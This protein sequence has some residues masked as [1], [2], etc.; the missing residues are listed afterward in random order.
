VGGTARTRTTL[1][2]LL[3]LLVLPSAAAAAPTDGGAQRIDSNT[4]GWA[5]GDGV[6]NT[7]SVT[8]DGTF[9][10]FSDTAANI[11]AGTGCT[12]V[13]TKSVRCAGTLADDVYVVGWDGNDTITLS[14]AVHLLACGGPGDDTI[15]SA[16]A[17]D[18]L[19][20]GSGDDTLTSGEG[21]DEDYGDLQSATDPCAN[22]EPGPFA[23]GTN[24]I[25][26]GGGADALVGA[27]GHD[28]LDGGAAGDLFLA[29]DGPDT[30][31]GGPG[32]D[33]ILAEGGNDTADG[34]TDNDAIVGATGDDELGGG[35]GQ[36]VIGGGA[37]NDRESGGP[38]RDLLGATHSD[39]T[40]LLPD[41]GNDVLSGDEG[42]DTMLG[43][44]GFL[45]FD[46]SP[47]ETSPIDPATVDTVTGADV[48]TGG[49]GIDTASYENRTTPVGVSLNGVADDGTGPEGDN[50]Q[51]AEIIVGGRAGDS[52]VGGPADDTIDGGPGG[53]G[54]RGEGGA[55]TLDGGATDAA[56]DTIDGGDGGDTLRGGPGV[57]ALSGARGR[58]TADGQAGDDTV[59]GGDDDD[60]VSGGSG[61]DGVSGDEGNDTVRGAAEG[62]VG[63][64]GRDALSGG[65]GADGL[66]GGEG[67]DSLTGGPGPDRLEGDDGNDTADYRGAGVSVSVSLDGIPGDGAAGEND[68]IQPDVESVATGEGDDTLVGSPAENVLDAGGG[69]DFM[70]D[71][72]GADDVR[73]GAGRDVVRSR[74]D[75]AEAVGCGEGLDF[76]IADEDDTVNDDCERVD[77]GGDRDPALGRRVLVTAKQGTY[78]LRPAGMRRIVPLRDTLLVPVRSLIDAQGG[79]VDLLTTTGSKRRRTRAGGAA[80]TIRQ[81]RKRGAPAEL[82]LPRRPTPACRRTARLTVLTSGPLRVRGARALV[83]APRAARFTVSD[84]C[85]STAVR[86]QRGR[87]S[88]TAPG[89]RKKS[90]RAGHGLVV[91]ARR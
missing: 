75:T 33:A 88:V 32:D 55:D 7:V 87:V 72:G 1:L 59:A 48:L 39:G 46:I 40:T 85:R 5:G 62:L 47:G 4:V 52:L 41:T 83:L 31:N 20:G 65:A 73:G 19:I 74:D 70:D 43:G 24:T 64:D 21:N 79:V 36:D 66:V 82:R 68:D 56:G 10:M 80:F 84:R 9:W 2:L 28:I 81:R 22:D 60:T 89:G 71:P 86:V 6:N 29:A 67:D 63:A 61:G 35:D 12:P 37:G 49:G 3:V 57:D 25:D 27:G 23:P 16:S 11:V 69:D 15:T 45:V 76:A 58:D 78:G 13:T 17:P 90:V 14:A 26:G 34:G 30:I 54:I 18:T 42:D 44:P 38:S 51:D 91:G 77:D 53:D 50:V 8:F